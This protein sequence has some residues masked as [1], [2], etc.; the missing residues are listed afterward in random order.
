MWGPHL[1][2]EK[3]KGRM[4]DQADLMEASTDWLPSFLTWYK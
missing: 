1:L 4:G 2:L 3:G